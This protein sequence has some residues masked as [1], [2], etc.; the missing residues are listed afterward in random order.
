MIDQKKKVYIIK[1]GTGSRPVYFVPVTLQLL[2]RGELDIAGH[3]PP[4]ELKKELRYM[5][6][7]RL[8]NVSN[9]EYESVMIFRLPMN[10]RGIDAISVRIE[11]VREEIVVEVPAKRAPHCANCGKTF[12]VSDN[13][14]PNPDGTGLV[15]E[16]CEAIRHQRNLA[17]IPRTS[18]VTPVPITT[19]ARCKQA[20]FPQDDKRQ[21]PAHGWI[22]MSCYRHLA[23][24]AK[25]VLSKRD[26]HGNESN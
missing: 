16:D 23:A 13:M 22:C 7:D 20:I 6:E 14:F 15:C 10:D 17:S 24:L 2:R 4:E 26:D 1:P 25:Q 18:F 12:R 21:T 9:G 5:E 3:E 8:T 11:H 19:C